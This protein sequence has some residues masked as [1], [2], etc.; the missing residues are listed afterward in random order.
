MAGVHL[1]L[2]AG[3]KPAYVA[4]WQ[5]WVDGAIVGQQKWFS[6]DPDCPESEREAKRKAYDHRQEMT[7][8]HYE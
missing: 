3:R 5:Q 6:Y 4:T 7:D 2:R 1:R 8:K